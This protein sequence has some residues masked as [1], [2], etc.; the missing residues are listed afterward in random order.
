[1]PPRGLIFGSLAF[2]AAFGAERL[3]A[4]LSKDIAR[5][6]RMRAMSG[7]PPLGRQLLSSLGGAIGQFGVNERE[8]AT[9]FASSL[10]ADVVR[11]A[12]MRG[13]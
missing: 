12:K 3:F 5:Y 11:Y 13:M 8:Q 1:M 4:S 2:A 9:G 10:I 6:D 7:E